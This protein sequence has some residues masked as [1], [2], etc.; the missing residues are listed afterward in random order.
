MRV[1]GV[2]GS[3]EG[4]IVADPRLRRLT[5]VRHLSQVEA[6]LIAVDIPLAFPDGGEGRDAERAARKVLG[7]RA[8]SVFS[9]P[10]RAVYDARD[11][12]AACDVARRLTG[13]AISR[14]T[15]GLRDKVLDAAEALTSGAR[16]IE[17]HPETAFAVIGGAPCQWSKTT[18]A[19]LRERAGLLEAEGLDP[20]SFE[21]TTGRAAPHDVLDAIAAAWVAI[22]K[23]QGSA[24]RLGEGAGPIWA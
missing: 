6:D 3:P 8:S 19:G 2:D 20:A 17:A 7:K 12:E 21:G 5:H 14:Q 16:L 4:W 1:V 22:R 9:T 10:P 15:W 23:H 24:I 18:W 13:K 11:Y